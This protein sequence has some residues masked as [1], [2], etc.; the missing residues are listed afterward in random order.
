MPFAAR[1]FFR[2]GRAGR[3]SRVR[4]ARVSQRARRKDGVETQCWS[5]YVQGPHYPFP[6]SQ[7][8]DVPTS[9]AEHRGRSTNRPCQ[10]VLKRRCRFAAPRTMKRPPLTRRTR[11]ALPQK[12]KG[13]R[14][15]RGAADRT[16]QGR[17]H[18]LMVWP[19]RATRR[20]ETQALPGEHRS[21]APARA[22]PRFYSSFDLP[23]DGFGLGGIGSICM[24][25][26]STDG[27]L[28]PS[29]GC[30]GYFGLLRV[31][32]GFF[33]SIFASCEPR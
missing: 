26:V 4:L 1:R 8:N 9:S 15:K 3:C 6:F 23:I 22:V 14:S 30:G 12:G 25:L 24:A 19:L 29:F 18:L 16:F 13:T 7:R 27:G 2:F 33:F 17:L 28:G 5:V 21:G 11:A 31:A 32:F 20:F 10:P